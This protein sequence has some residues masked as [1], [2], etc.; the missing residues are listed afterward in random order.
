MDVTMVGKDIGIGV[1][2]ASILMVLVPDSFWQSLF[3]TGDT[4]LP[5][6]VVLSWNAIIGIIVAIVAF[7]CSVGNI[8]MA[9]D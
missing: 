1:I 5:H 3:L 9:A 8:V 6:F 7:V 4:A 2:I